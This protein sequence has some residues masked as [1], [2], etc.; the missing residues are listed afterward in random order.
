MDVVIIKRNVDSQAGEDRR[1]IIDVIESSI[2]MGG[3]EGTIERYNR[4][5]ESV[6]R[7]ADSPAIDRK[8]RSLI[9]DVEPILESIIN[10]V[11]KPIEVFIKK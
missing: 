11:K 4:I 10:Y 6:N 9:S 5:L 2:T 3:R 1:D 8:E 7:I